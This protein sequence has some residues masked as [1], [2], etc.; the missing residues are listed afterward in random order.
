M[1][2]RWLG[3]MTTQELMDYTGWSQP[4]IFKLINK[5][6]LP[7]VFVTGTFQNKQVLYHDKAQVD[8]VIAE[9]DSYITMRQLEQKLGFSYPALMLRVRRK[10]AGFPQPTSPKIPRNYCSR[11]I[12]FRKDDVE[13]FIKN[14]PEFCHGWLLKAG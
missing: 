7:R 2:L 3:D 10:A 1:S 5:G 4:F 9:M 12:W 6:V 14:A 13:Q 8:A 11:I